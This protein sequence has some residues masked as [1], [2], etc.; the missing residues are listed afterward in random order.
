MVNY[1]GLQFWHLCS[2]SPSTGEGTSGPKI[3]TVL[4]YRH[5]HLVPPEDISSTLRRG[6]YFTRNQD[7]YKEVNMVEWNSTSNIFELKKKMAHS[8]IV[9][10]YFL[11]MPL[12]LVMVYTWFR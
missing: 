2:L 10:S 11:L 3:A 12:L 1:T 7:S 5:L 9:F 8:D 6:I 4:C